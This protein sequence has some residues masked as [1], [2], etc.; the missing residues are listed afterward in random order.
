MTDQSIIDLYFARNEQAILETEKAHG[1]VCMAISMG[2]L[3]DRMDAEECVNDT[4]LKAWNSIPPTIPRSLRAFL[5]RIV[6]NLSI[7][8]YRKRRADRAN[9]DVEAVLEELAE[10]LPDTDELPA[11]N[12]L[13]EALD[14]FLRKVSEVDR[15]LF[16]GRYW[17]GASVNVLAE[18]SG[19]SPNAVTKRLGKTRERLRVYLN[20]RGYS[21]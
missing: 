5:S 15:R 11:E 1:A 17:H 3:N 12:T 18:G 19:L 9:L 7:D 20:E 21:V 6:R 8:R 13:S 4:Y 10:C 2:S 14:T 16:L